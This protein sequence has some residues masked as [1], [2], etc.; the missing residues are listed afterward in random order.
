M[1]CMT[2]L[3]IF[4]PVLSAT[5]VKLTLYTKKSGDS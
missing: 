5:T 2:R 3:A 1:Y 4:R